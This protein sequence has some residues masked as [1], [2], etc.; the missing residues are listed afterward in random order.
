VPTDIKALGRKSIA[1]SDPKDLIQPTYKD[2]RSIRFAFLSVDLF[3]MSDRPI[4]VR[5]MGSSKR[6]EVMGRIP[7]FCG[8]S[9]SKAINGALLTG[10]GVGYLGCSKLDVCAVGATVYESWRRLSH[11]NAV[12]TSGDFML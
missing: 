4:T 11:Q 1:K 10:D 8:L 3:A 5:H 2:A 9:P 6:V 7:L 12:G